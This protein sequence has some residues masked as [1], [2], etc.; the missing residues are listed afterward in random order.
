MKWIFYLMKKG[1]TLAQ[2]SDSD[3]LLMK[4]DFMMNSENLNLFKITNKSYVQKF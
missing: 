2:E 4:E 1:R 3:F